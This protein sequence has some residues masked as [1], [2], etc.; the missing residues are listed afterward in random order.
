MVFVKTSTTSS[1]LTPKYYWDICP[2]TQN[3]NQRGRPGSHVHVQ[4]E[5]LQA[6]EGR[7]QCI[8]STL[9]GA[10]VCL[11]MSVWCRDLKERLHVATA[12]LQNSSL[13]KLY[14]LLNKVYQKNA[15]LWG[16]GYKFTLE[17]ARNKSR[18]VFKNSE[19]SL[20]DRH[21]NYAIWP[22]WSWDNWVQSWEPYL[23][24]LGKNLGNFYWIK[25]K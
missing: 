2:S 6:E 14:L 24:N 25:I 13:H 20:S 10:L 23:I 15:S 18:V 11:F 17:G 1:A 4:L 7:L 3:S 8:G 21:K 22:I 19:N 5:D 9:T 16:F 12:N